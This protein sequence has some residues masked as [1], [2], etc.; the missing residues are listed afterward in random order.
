M[1]PRIQVIL[2]KYI[3]SAEISFHK[4]HCFRATQDQKLI[5]I[6]TVDKYGGIHSAKLLIGHLNFLRLF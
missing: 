6:H 1:D 2:D 4:H 3:R 5:Q